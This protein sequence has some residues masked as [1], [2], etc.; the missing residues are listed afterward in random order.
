LLHPATV[1]GLSNH[2][3]ARNLARRDRVMR[4]A[5]VKRATKETDVA[6][7][8]DLDGRGVAS[9]ST[10]IGFLDHMTSTGKMRRVQFAEALAYRALTDELRRAA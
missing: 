2:N 7:T 3:A 9:I 8:I 6:V 1:A 5:A 10:G 4:K